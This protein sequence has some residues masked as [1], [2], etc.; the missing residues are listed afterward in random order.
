MNFI[1]RL[2]HHI[3]LCTLV[4]LSCSAT[5]AIAQTPSCTSTTPIAADETPVRMVFGGDI[6]LGNSFVVENIPKEWEANYFAG[7]RSVLK[8]ADFAFGNFEDTLTEHKKT[9]KNTA[10]GRAYAFRSP[11]HYAALMYQEGFRAVNVA[12]N[13]ANDFGDIGFK[14][15]LTNLQQAGIA[16]AG[17]RDEAATLTVRGLNIAMLGF[18]YSS[19]FNTVFDLEAGA[20]LVRQAKRPGVYVIVTFHAGAEG[21]AAVWHGDEEEEFLGENRGNTV[22]FSRAMIDAGADI[23]VGHGPHVLRAAECY[24]DKPIVYSLGNFVG[25]GGLSA[26]NFAAVS[27]LLEISV[28]LDGSLQQIN[29]VPVRFNDQKLPQIDQQ[30]FGTRLVNYLGH[31]A[32]YG[33]NFI[34]FPLNSDAE[35]EFSAWLAA[36]MPRPTSVKK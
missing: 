6:V 11:P 10:T 21:S 30:E 27:A 34:E 16:V 36:N 4:F 8:R 18:T 12:N 25:V 7:V 19:R 9:S 5:S 14:D 35:G 26:K 1:F 23:V 15:T 33:G 31:H 24:H 28:A 20:T 2:T 32:M 13:H 29:L 3:A 17:L 22:A